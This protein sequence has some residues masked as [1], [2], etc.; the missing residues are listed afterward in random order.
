MSWRRDGGGNRRGGDR[1]DAG[2]GSRRWTLADQHRF[3]DQLDR[4]FDTR[5]RRLDEHDD[6]IGRLSTRQ[7]WIAGAVALGLV[8][9]GLVVRFLTAG[10]AP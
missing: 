7:A 4:R 1:D 2:F 5:D 10:A 9:V 6:Q 3:E 8:V